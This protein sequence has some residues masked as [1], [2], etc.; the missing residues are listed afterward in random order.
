MFARKNKCSR[1]KTLHEYINDMKPFK[2]SLEESLLDNLDD[3][4]NDS[5]ETVSKINTIGYD[6]DMESTDDFGTV[7]K[8][9]EKELKKY[10][11]VWDTTQFK[12]HRG[13][14]NRKINKK[15]NK[16]EQAVGDIILGLDKNALNDPDPKPGNE[17]YDFFQ[18]IL[19]KHFD[20]IYKSSLHFNKDVKKGHVG[21]TIVGPTATDNIY[22][23]VYPGSGYSFEVKLKRKK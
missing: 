16:K 17:L 11:K 2:T 22:I 18:S 5:D 10:P 13:Y 3:L 1:M 20:D 12:S 19:Q 6:W 8:M 9:S 4:E 14:I 7:E 15:P 21:L 23:S